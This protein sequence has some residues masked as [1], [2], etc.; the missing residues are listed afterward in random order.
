[1]AVTTGWRTPPY[2]T[3]AEPIS[4]DLPERRRPQQR[5]QP[6][7]RQL[8]KT[9]EVGSHGTGGKR[10]SFAIS[11]LQFQLAVGRGSRNA[12]RCLLNQPLQF[13]GPVLQLHV[14]HEMGS[15]MQH[16][17]HPISVQPSHFSYT[18]FTAMDA[19]GMCGRAART[20]KRS[21][22]YELTV[23]TCSQPCRCRRMLP[24]GVAQTRADLQAGARDARCG[25][26]RCS[27]GF[28]PAGML[29]ACLHGSCGACA[30]CLCQATCETVSSCCD[31]P[32]TRR[33]RA[34]WVEC[35]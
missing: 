11:A 20:R 16:S 12:R 30:L 19:S 21:N 1:M 35:A 31:A 15:G 29:F 23:C 18:H 27:T 28:N 13:Q 10:F 22:I 8:P 32:C 7:P 9:G 33:D 4:G 6:K 26:G 34:A 2:R 24:R 3:W 17:H 14:L 25:A 5:G